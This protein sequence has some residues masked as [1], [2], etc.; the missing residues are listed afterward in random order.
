MSSNK[1][2]CGFWSFLGI[3]G[4]LLIGGWY[5]H[6]SGWLGKRL[7]PIEGA[8]VIPDEAIVT[9]FITTEPK[10]WSELPQL[11]LPET[12]KLIEENLNNLQQEFSD[13]ST[14]DYQQ[15]IQP[16]L[17]GVMIAILP[18]QLVTK[19]AENVLIVVGI[20]NKLKA[21]RF[22]KKTQQ[23]AK[24]NWQERKYKGIN[25]TEFPNKN[26]ETINSAWLGNKLAISSNK[27]I[28]EQAIDTYKGERS[29]ASEPNVK[30][31]L[32][33]KL[34]VENPVAQVYFTNFS[35]LIEQVAQEEI[36]LTA[37]AELQQLDSVVMGVGIQSE[38]IHLQSITNFNSSVEESDL[39]A[40]NSQI[41]TKL[42]FN[43]I[44]A[45]NGKNIQN[46]WSTTVQQIEADD[47]L[48][49]VLD[50]GRLSFRYGT[51]LDLDRDIFSWMDGEFA[52]GLM[53]TEK[54]NIPEFG[55]GLESVIILETSN[56]NQAKLSLRKIERSLKSNLGIYS[57]QKQIAN[58]L[59]ITE[60]LS[61]S[62]GF[63][64]THGWVDKNYLVFSIGNS[65]FKSINSSNNNS[66]EENNQFKAIAQK[67]PNNNFGYFYLNLE[68]AMPMIQKFPAES[69]NISTETMT[70][71]NS[72]Q[73]VGATATMPDKLTSKLD[74]L[75]MFK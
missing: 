67:L 14:I 13:S 65:V 12:E 35:Y 40:T 18:E 4:F 10:K 73:G 61:P 42:P 59:T 33:Q 20:K 48:R 39:L 7:T 17:G 53:K 8:K 44:L 63:F 46:I 56:P 75:V 58:Q 47:D 38:E 25:I 27:K 51:G 2:G 32:S 31:I 16:W 64:V 29:L 1:F 74:V 60:W 22:I 66:F 9:S 19:E 34:T 36:S 24:E 70:V 23:Q 54:A 57:R 43:T 37:L 3:T 55:I 6:F 30:Q 45:L 71:L 21:L 15:D 68:Q 26:N 5:I 11:G 28:L 62:G 52:L 69:I 50:M 49:R 41:L 72:L